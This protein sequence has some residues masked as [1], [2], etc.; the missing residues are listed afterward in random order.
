MTKHD[1]GVYLEEILDCISHIGKYVSGKTK[2]DF[3]TD[4][5][6]LDGV[7]MRLQQIGEMAAKIDEN[8]RQQAPEIPWKSVIGF[9]NKVAHEYV[10]LEVDEIWLIIEKDLP[11]LKDSISGLLSFVDSR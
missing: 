10:Y 7:C 3:E 9:R 5:L 11:K 2:E 6:L 1:P 4:E 8:I